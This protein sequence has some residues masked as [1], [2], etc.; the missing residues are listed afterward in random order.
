MSDAVHALA[1]TLASVV[2]LFELWL[3]LWLRLRLRLWLWLWVPIERRFVPRARAAHV[4]TPATYPG[5]R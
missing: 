1:A 3:W 2:Q 4:G 5:T